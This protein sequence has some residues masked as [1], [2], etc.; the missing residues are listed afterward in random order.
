[1]SES[2][3]PDK[4]HSHTPRD[5]WAPPVEPA[6]QQPAPAPADAAP[7]TAAQVAAAPADAEAAPAAQPFG[8]AKPSPLPPSPGLPEAPTGFALPGADATAGGPPPVPG[9]AP[10]PGPEFGSPAMPPPPPPGAGPYGQPMPYPPYGYPGY[11]GYPMSPYGA[12]PPPTARNGF[13]TAAM[14]LGIVGA[15]LGIACFGAALGL[16]LGIAAIIFG[17]IGL[18]LANRGEATNRSQALT[19]LILGIVA[20]LVSAAMIAFFVTGIMTGFFDGLDE[21]NGSTISADGGYYDEPLH[22]GGGATYDDGLVVTVTAVEP[23]SG[24][25]GVSDG[26]SALTFTVTVVNN[27]DS[28]ADLDGSEITAY[29]D[30][31]DDDPLQDMSTNDGLTG[32]LEP[33]GAQSTKVVVIVPDTD[34]GTI[35]LE[36]APGYD[37]DYAYWEVSA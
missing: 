13:G 16:P 5:P 12:W 20:T 17:I 6:P 33:D 34:D 2:D 32:D 9:P 36:I 4:P 15:V 3:E 28:T 31:D 11:P 29:A 10:A 27:G 23:T 26:G 7:V 24:L 14:V 21:G 30:S 37:Y 18:R 22:E 25:E 1:M 8:L 19:G 35:Q